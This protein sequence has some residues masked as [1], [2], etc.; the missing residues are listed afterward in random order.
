VFSFAWCT[1][2]NPKEPKGKA[3]ADLPADP[4]GE[5]TVKKKRTPNMGLFCDSKSIV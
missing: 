1:R 5:P 3:I 4:I 2:G